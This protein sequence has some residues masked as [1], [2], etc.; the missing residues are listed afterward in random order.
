VF[1]SLY[2]GF[3]IPTLEA[4]SCN[5]P[6]LLSNQSSLP[7][8]GGDAALYFDPYDEKDMYEKISKVITDAELRSQ[9]IEKGRIQLQ[10][11]NWNDIAAQTIECY[12][13]VL[14]AGKDK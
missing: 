9:M 5:C 2:E 8:V 7:E 14:E 4:F 12:K 6:V 3:G 13:K 11:F 10:K 1:P